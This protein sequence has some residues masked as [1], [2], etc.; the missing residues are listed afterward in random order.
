MQHGLIRLALIGLLAVLQSCNSTD[1]LTPQVGIGDETLQSST[2]TQG[3]LDR[4]GTSDQPVGAAQ[5]AA[6]SGDAG[7]TATSLAAEGSTLQAQADALQRNNVNPVASGDPTAGQTTTV[8]TDQQPAVTEN[9]ESAADTTRQTAALDPAAAGTGTIRF[10][11]IIGAPVQAVT[12]LSRKLGA[13]A[14]A[15]GL[16]IRS[17]TDTSSQHILKGYLSAMTDNGKTTVVYVWDVLDGS[18]GRLHRIQGQDSVSRTADD[19]WAAVPPRT[20]ETI[21]E[22]TIDAYLEWRQQQRG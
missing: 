1:A 6:M 8:L 13:L 14:R 22:R 12:P 17:S 10:L 7:S 3:D 21:A 11:P 9:A 16:T 18:G 2:V 19:P 5:Q 4:A 20:M 15:N